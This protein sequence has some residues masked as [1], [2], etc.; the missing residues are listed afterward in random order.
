M[1]PASR[2]SSPRLRRDS[3]IGQ[4]GLRPGVSGEQRIGTWCALAF[5]RGSVLLR[6]QEWGEDVNHRV[7][8]VGVSW[9]TV[10]RTTRRW[11]GALVDEVRD[12]PSSAQLL[13]LG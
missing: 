10:T 7:K 9:L 8:M 13:M 4:L 12:R 5:A 1:R 11:G 6:D 3:V 2:A